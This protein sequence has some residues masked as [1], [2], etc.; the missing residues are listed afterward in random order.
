MS[1]YKA[2]YIQTMESKLQEYRHDNQV[3]ASAL[4]EAIDNSVGWGKANSITIVKTNSSISV[5]DNGHVDDDRERFSEWLAFGKKNNKVHGSDAIG[6]FGLGLPKGSVLLGNKLSVIALIDGIITTTQCNWERMIRNNNHIPT[7][8]DSTHEE[9]QEFKENYDTQ[10][11]LVKYENLFESSKELTIEYIH[12]ITCAQFDTN[13]E[14]S[15]HIKLVQVFDDGRENNIIQIHDF[16]DTTCWESTYP[17]YKKSLKILKVEKKTNPSKKKLFIIE[18]EGIKYFVDKDGKL[19]EID[20]TDYDEIYGAEVKISAIDDKFHAEGSQKLYENKQ[21]PELI[22]AKVYRQGRDITPFASLNLGNSVSADN[23]MYRSKGSRVIF[24]FNTESHSEDKKMKITSQFDR[25]WGV[26]SLKNITNEAF[27][28]YR[29]EGQ[30]ECLKYIGNE[31]CKLYEKKKKDHKGKAEYEIREKIRIINAD[32]QSISTTKCEELIATFDRLYDNGEYQPDDPD[33]KDLFDFDRRNGFYKEF[34]STYYTNIIANLKF[35]LENPNQPYE[36]MNVDSAEES[37]DE[38]EHVN[39]SINESPQPEQV[40][41][42]SEEPDQSEQVNQLSDDSTEMEQTN[43]SSNDPNQP[44]DTSTEVDQTKQYS[45]EQLLTPENFDS[46]NIDNE[47][48][49][50]SSSD[51]VS[52]LNDIKIKGYIKKYRET[53]FDML[54]FSNP[55]HQTLIDGFSQKLNQTLYSLEVINSM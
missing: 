25:E 44:S 42:V 47:T 54:D 35:I 17:I 22:G 23:G 36:G 55:E 5:Y 9:I 15:P 11:V 2:K 24:N 49:Y 52:I 39:S 10:G 18:E 43:Q 38:E 1:D 46:E 6:K 8:R 7:V 33:C 3:P 51:D 53:I 41:Q 48:F 20:S 27:G 26:T 4:L 12:D 28:A 40:N 31:A 29:I 34:H 14:N 19:I 16:V 37:L 32:P 21:D 45:S 13:Y 30:K 50:D